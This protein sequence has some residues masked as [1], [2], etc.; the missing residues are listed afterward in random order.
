[1]SSPFVDLDGCPIPLSRVLGYGRTGVVIS[2]D[3]TAAVKLPIRW[4][5]DT[6][7]DF[8]MNLVSLR[9]EQDIYIGAR[10]GR[11][12]GIVPCVGCSG[13]AIELE[14]M[15]NGDLRSYPTQCRP[16]RPFQL[17]WFRDMARALAHTHDRR[18]LVADIA[19]RN[20]LQDSNLRNKPRKA[21][22]RSHNADEGKQVRSR[23]RDYWVV[24]GGVV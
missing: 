24:L 15:K 19:S 10:I 16:L 12:S 22:P 21:K 4:A 1:M 3:D 9:R 6:G 13:M 8:D 2:H 18:V 20:F 11:C 23:G 14:W 17:S 5:G 7:S